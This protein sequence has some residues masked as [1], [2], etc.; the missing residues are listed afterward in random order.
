LGSLYTF[1]CNS[2]DYEV[3]SV[4]KQDRGFTAVLKPYI[5]NDCKEVCDVLIGDINGVIPEDMLDKLLLSNFEL[6]DFYNC[7]NCKSK[8]L[9]E[10]NSENYN[11]PK[12]DGTMAKDKNKPVLLWD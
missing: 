7:S 4:G 10:W 12:C 11:C 3:E 9:T 5:C 1:K 8:N 6:D 2:C